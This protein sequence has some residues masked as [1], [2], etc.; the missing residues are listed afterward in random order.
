MATLQVPGAELYYEV[1]GNGVPVVLV[2]GLALDARMWD[3][4]LTADGLRGG[5]ERLATQ[6]LSASAWVLNSSRRATA[7][8]TLR[9]T[10]PAPDDFRVR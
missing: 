10:R 2:H 7:R 8:R 1:T 3:P 5:G 4:Q 6:E 9:R